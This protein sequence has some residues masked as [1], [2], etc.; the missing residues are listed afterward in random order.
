MKETLLRGLQGAVIGVFITFTIGFTMILLT[1]NEFIVTSEFIIKQ[2][3][4]GL[5]LGFAFGALNMLFNKENLK[6]ARTTIFHSLILT[7][8][9]IPIGIYAGWLPSN[10]QQILL[11]ITIFILIYFLI[12]I[13]CYIFYKKEINQINEKLKK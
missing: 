8:L 7:I 3:V 6:L 10:W 4:S 13:I 1:K 12:W 9:F 11:A 5:I 2:Y